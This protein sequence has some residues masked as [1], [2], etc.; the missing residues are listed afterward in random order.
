[1]PNPNGKVKILEHPVWSDLYKE[2]MEYLRKK[3]EEEGEEFNAPVYKEMNNLYVA[4]I[5][6]IDIGA[7]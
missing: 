1:M 2:Q 4:G 7:N 5:D 3:A 6:G